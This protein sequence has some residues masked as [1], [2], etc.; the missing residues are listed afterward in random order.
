MKRIII[1]LIGGLLLTNTLW[2]QTVE[3]LEALKKTKKNAI[4][5]LEKEVK[6]IQH[7]IDSLPQRQKAWENNAFGTLGFN[8][9]IFNNWFQK[10]VPNS[11]GGAIGITVNATANYNASKHFWRNA[12]ALK[13]GW[14][15]FDDRDN[16]DDE[17]DYRVATDIFNISSLYGRKLTKTV[18]AS[19]RF[20]YRS[21]IVE[22]FNNPGYLDFGIGGT[23]DPEKGLFVTLH[24]LN[25]NLVLSDA[26][27]VYE[28]TVGAQLV[29]DY[30]RNFSS[31]ISI[32][33]N[34]SGFLSYRNLN[35][36]NWTWTNTLSYKVWKVIG[37]GFEGGL[38]GN[39]QETL[40]YEINK[41]G[42][43]DAT[44]DTISDKLQSYFLAGITYKF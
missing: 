15:K 29:A 22:N 9:S 43:E 2:G 1:L 28:S 37:I 25:A 5:A 8:T 12:G 4:A 42:N 44:F 40:D 26:G 10:S 16:P 21:G 36:S 32:K 13:L 23:W 34:F 7:K 33:S 39:R 11:S 35:R 30:S 18:A 41:L 24:P 38:R 6:E 19:A 14:V 17:M 27:S 20:E 3:E 31:G